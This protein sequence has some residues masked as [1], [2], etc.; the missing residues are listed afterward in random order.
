MKKTLLQ[1]SASWCGP[2]NA[3]SPI[4]TKVAESLDIGLQKIDIDDD[5]NKDI[6]SKFQI[7]SIP[8]VILFE[9][10]KPVDQFVGMKSEQKIINFINRD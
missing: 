7:R 1:F 3:L 8:T 2:C 4:L 9:D 6:V 10:N 5:K